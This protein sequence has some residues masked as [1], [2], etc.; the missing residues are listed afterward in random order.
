MR[1]NARATR[2]S[3]GHA[4]SNDRATSQ[5]RSITAPH[6][7]APHRIASHRIRIASHPHR[8]RIGVASAHSHRPRHVQGL[9]SGSGQ[10][11][12]CTR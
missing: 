4:R 7:T 10:Y 5:T 1:I 2:P 9:S 3:A 11:T 8:I 12:V 6:R